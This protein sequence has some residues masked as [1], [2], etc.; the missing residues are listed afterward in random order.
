MPKK[1]LPRDAPRAYDLTK[2]VDAVL[3][4]GR[5]GLI[6]AYTSVGISV[7]ARQQGAGSSLGEL[8]VPVE[9][10]I[11]PGRSYKHSEKF[12]VQT[13]L[14]YVTHFAPPGVPSFYAYG[15]ELWVSAYDVGDY[16]VRATAERFGA[17]AASLEEGQQVYAKMRLVRMRERNRDYSDIPFMRPPESPFPY[18]LKLEPGS[19]IEFCR[20][21]RMEDNDNVKHDKGPA[22][23][24]KRLESF[25]SASGKDLKS[26]IRPSLYD[27]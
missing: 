15:K 24:P 7:I 14:N 13:S 23:A 3:G 5:H 21:P 8:C 25:D 17:V 9:A 27:F 12:F 11:V 20:G 10:I 26:L 16:E 22:A 18:R 4:S 6:N 19:S 1:T 2:P